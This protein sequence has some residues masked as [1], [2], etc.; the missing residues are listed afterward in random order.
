MA[1]VSFG[2]RPRLMS[3]SIVFGGEFKG[4]ERA[5]LLSVITYIAANRIL[6]ESMVVSSL[7]SER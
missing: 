6:H 3:M 2:E 1:L 4:A 5:T 7:K